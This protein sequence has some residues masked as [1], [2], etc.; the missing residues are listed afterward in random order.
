MKPF[1]FNTDQKYCLYCGQPESVIKSIIYNEHTGKR[2]EHSQCMNINCKSGC[3]N[4]GGHRYNRWFFGL[5]R[6]RR[7]AR[8][9]YNLLDGD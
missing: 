8:C 5:I 6:E 7:C 2:Y 3:S 4:N 1:Q 9:G